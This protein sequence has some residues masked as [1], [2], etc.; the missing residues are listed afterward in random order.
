MKPGEQYALAFP[1]RARDLNTSFAAGP[2]TLNARQALDNWRHWSSSAMALI[3]PPA[4]GKSHLAAM[5]ANA[6]DGVVLMRDVWSGNAE[7]CIDAHA[8]RPLVLEDADGL[9]AA[10][11]SHANAPSTSPDALY[12]LLNAAREGRVSGVLITAR[13]PPSAWAPPGA[14]ADLTS[15]LNNLP[16]LQVSDPNDEELEQLLL[17]LFADRGVNVSASV[18]LYLVRRMERTHA[19]AVALVDALDTRAFAQNT[20]ITTRLAAHYFDTEHDEP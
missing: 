4:C 11:G 18:V 15:R 7:Q 10:S 16:T 8:G 6:N 14:S 13:T 5:W 20:K 9:A 19:A 3:G 17:K 12:T 2:S 1:P